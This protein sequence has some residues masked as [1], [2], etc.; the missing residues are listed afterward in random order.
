MILPV[1]LF[2][3]LMK[4]QL[5]S[6]RLLKLSGWRHIIFFFFLDL[7]HLRIQVAQSVVNQ[8]FLIV[9]FRVFLRL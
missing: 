9:F 2:Q 3:R 8:N 6:Q 7:F 5:S 4:S 1:H